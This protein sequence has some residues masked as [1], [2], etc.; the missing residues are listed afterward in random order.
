MLSG[1]SSENDL[2]TNHTL[3]KIINERSNCAKQ[4][5]NDSS[6]SYSVEGI[7]RLLEI[8]HAGKIK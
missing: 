3:E 8:A 6:S 5:L 1:P 4:L 2:Q 7:K